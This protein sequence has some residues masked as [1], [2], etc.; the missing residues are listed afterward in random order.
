MDD[1]IRTDADRLAANRVMLACGFTDKQRDALKSN[2]MART[3][4][5]A[6]AAQDARRPHW[7]ETDQATPEAMEQLR[8]ARIKA[9]T[10]K[11]DAQ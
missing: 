3:M 11:D 4:D 5:E 6:Q 8:R 1:R 2:P 7:T 10:I 9:G